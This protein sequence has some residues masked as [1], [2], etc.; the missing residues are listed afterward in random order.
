MPYLPK[1]G[2]EGSQYIPPQATA[3]LRNFAPSEP[4]PLV[5]RHRRGF[6]HFCRVGWRMATQRSKPVVGGASRKRRA[7][8]RP[9]VSRLAQPVWELAGIAESALTPQGRETLAG[10]LAESEAM[11]REL[12]EARARI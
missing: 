7:A 1:R 4:A 10:M 3:K 11:R 9:V 12:E 5:Y 2:R 6:I 8:D